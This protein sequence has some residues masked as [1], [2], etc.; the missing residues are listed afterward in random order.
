MWLIWFDANSRLWSFGRRCFSV[1]LI[2]TQS[3]RLIV[4]DASQPRSYLP[5]MKA[6]MREALSSSTVTS[7]LSI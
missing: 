5:A 6:A 2:C 3:T 1:S 7:T 4:P